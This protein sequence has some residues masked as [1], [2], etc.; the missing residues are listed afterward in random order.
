MLDSFA[1]LSKHCWGHARAVHMVSKSYGLSSHNALQVP[2]SLGVAAP[3]CTPLP[4]WTQQL[5]T[6]L[7]KQ[8][9]ELLRP[10]ARSLKLAFVLLHI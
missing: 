4:T 10:F 5:P 1:Q 9:W 6:M 7:T 8:Y 3:A 2:V